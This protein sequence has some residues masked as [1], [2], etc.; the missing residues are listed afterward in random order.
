MALRGLPPEARDAVDVVFVTVDPARDTVPVLRDYMG[1]FSEDFVA[2]T[3]TEDEIVEALTR[4]G[5]G[6]PEIA[7]L[8]GGRYAVGHPA[9]VLAITPDACA[10][11]E[12]PF[13]TT[14]G[15]YREDLT[16]L[17]EERWRQP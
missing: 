14:V 1:L 5:F 12:Y 11:L 8:G 4:F 6:P 15:A 7:D 16:R 3:G 9:G 2:L 13:G 17:V 10:G